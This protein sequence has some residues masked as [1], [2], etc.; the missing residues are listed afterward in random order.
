[1][2]AA[3]LSTRNRGAAVLIGI[4]RADAV[5]SLPATSIPRM[6][7]RV[8]G[9]I[10][11]STKPERDFSQT[12]DLYREGRLP[13]DRLISHRLPLEEAEHAFELMHSGD[14]CGWCSSCERGRSRRPDRR[15]LERRGR[16][17]ARTSTSSSRGAEARPRP[18]RS[19]MLAHPAPG[20]TPVLV[21]VGATPAEYEPVWPPTLMMNKAHRARRPPPD[22]HVGSG[23]ARDR[24]GRARRRRRR[25]PRGGRRDDRARRRL[26]RPGC[27]RRDRRPCGEP[28]RDPQGHRSLRRGSRPGCG[29]RRSSSAATR[30]RARTTAATECASLRSRRGDIGTRSTRRSSPPGI[31]SRAPTRTRPSSSSAPTTGS[32]G[33]QAATVCR[34]ASCSS[35]CSSAS[36]R[37]MPPRV[38]AVLETVDFHHGRNWTLEVAVWDL[39]GR[40]RGEPVWRLLGGTRDRILAYASTGELVS[41]EERV[42]R[43][44][45]LR[46][47]G[48]RAVKLRLHSADWRLDLPVVAGVRDAVGDALEIMV[49]ANQGWRMP[50]DTTPRWDLAHRRR[51]RRELERLDVYWLEEP[52]ATDDLEGYAALSRHGLSHRRRRDGADDSR[53]AR[54]D[55]PRRCR[56]RPGRRRPR[57]RHR[58]LSPGRRARRGR[59]PNVDASHVVER[60][61]AAR[62]PPRRSRALERA[63]TSRCRSTH[64]RG[65]PSGATGSSPSR[66]TSRRTGR[67]APPAGPGLGVVPDFG[68]ARAVPRRLMRIRAAVLREPG[69]PVAIEEVELDPPKRDEMLVRIAAAGVCHSDVRLADG[70]LGAGRWPCRARPRGCRSRRGGRRRRDARRGRRPRRAVLRPRVP[71]LPVLPRGNAQPVCRR[72]RGGCSRHAPRRHESAARLGRLDAAAR[73][74]DRLLRGLRS[75]RGWR[76]SAHSARPSAVAGG[77]PRMRGRHGYGRR[78]QRGPG[79]AGRFRRGHRLRRGGSPGDRGTP[80]RGREPDRRHRPRRGEASTRARA[81][82]DAR[83]RVPATTSS[84]RSDG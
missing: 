61:R 78:P 22:A 41:A 32:R 35:A 40:A 65:R 30:C 45:A 53:G 80:C 59:R 75:R 26:G 34:T 31:P 27:A 20:H 19:R 1:M 11:G 43:C 7:R 84:P 42:R 77:A 33:T 5:L 82:S 56:R 24:P 15:G 4:P 47:A 63:R 55:R 36:T 52:L 17:T 57:R 58:G 50:G 2:E 79:A 9:S 66:S 62:E 81:R 64:P 83:D 44:L 29:E 76:R 38:H 23:A 3:F 21:C 39:V 72:G 68:R 6:E 71:L 67:S 51:V 60:V 73:P 12:L 25:A 18:R 28:R 54:S 10:Y 8:L 37:P 49:D 69:R 14:A 48:V 46:D 13:L 70:E 16:R 74:A